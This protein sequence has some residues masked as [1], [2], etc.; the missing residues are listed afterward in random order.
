ML[1]LLLLGFGLGAAVAFAVSLLRAQRLA[2]Q[3]GYQAPVAARGPAAVTDVDVQ[4]LTST[5]P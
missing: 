2:Q 5:S 4:R 3:T 1:R